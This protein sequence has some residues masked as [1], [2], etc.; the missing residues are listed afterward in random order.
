MRDLLRRTSDRYW[1]GAKDERR[2][3]RNAQ[4]VISLL[5][6]GKRLPASI[7]AADVENMISALRAGTRNDDGTWKRRPLS[8]GRINRL[9][10]ALSK[11]MRY[12]Y[13]LGMVD[14]LP[15]I[16]RLKEKQGRL[17]W[18]TPAEEQLVLDRLALL[19]RDNLRDLVQVLLDS[20]MRLAEALGLSW[21]AVSQEGWIHL[22][23]GDCKNGTPRSIPTTERIDAVIAK[24]RAECPIG[25]DRVFWNLS[26]WQAEHHWSR[27]RKAIGLDHDKE[28]VIHALRH[29]FC[30]RL[31]QRGRQLNV[32]QALAGHK[33]ISVTLRYAHLAP[34]NLVEAIR[35]PQQ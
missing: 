2:S 34:A 10:A 6:G 21:R 3:L 29:T 13:H 27:M 24:R 32:V 4:I 16:S 28:F 35:G 25:E 5:G 9:L 20:G 19:K 14:R 1:K 33:A 30:S 15:M 18:L 26:Y 11:M 12:G 23:G 17:R 22:R 8:N 7:T 31:V